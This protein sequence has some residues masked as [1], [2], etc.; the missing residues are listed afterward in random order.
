MCIDNYSLVQII[1]TKANQKTYQ[2]QQSQFCL[3]SFYVGF[4]KLHIHY[5]FLNNRSKNYPLF[6]PLLAWYDIA[7][8]FIGALLWK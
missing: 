6:F 4:L 7:L 1:P 2:T 3:N 8:Q 5:D